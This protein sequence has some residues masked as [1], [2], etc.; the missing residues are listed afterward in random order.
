MRGSLLYDEDFLLDVT[1]QHRMLVGIGSVTVQR[2]GICV[3]AS[4]AKLKTGEEKQ[5]D[6]KS[7][8][9]TFLLGIK[10]EFSLGRYFKL[11]DHQNT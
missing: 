11:D 1:G 5:M 3:P 9:N 7:N 10:F 2:T 4:C 8:Q 6:T